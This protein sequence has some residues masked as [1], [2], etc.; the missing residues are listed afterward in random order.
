[1]IAAQMEGRICAGI[2][3]NPAYVDVI[4]NR[5]A[6]FVGDYGKVRYRQMAGK[7]HMKKCR[8]CE[9]TKPLDEF[10]LDKRRQIYAARCKQCHDLAPRI[11][12]VCGDGFIGKTGQKACTTICKSRLRPKTYRNCDHCDQRFG[13]LHHLRSRFCS[14]KCHHASREKGARKASA[15][16]TKQARAANKAIEYAIKV[17]RVHR[18]LTCDAC[19]RDGRI[20]AAHYDYKRRLD[21]RWLCVSC[22][23]KWDKADPKGGVVKYA[24]SAP[25]RW[26]NFT[27]EAATLDGGGTFEATKEDRPAGTRVEAVAV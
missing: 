9:E 6:Q 10:H 2:E 23:R 4:V 8:R 21:V 13:P 20:E 27:G 7:Y 18:P 19:S 25:K 11:C 26:Q 14:Q 15:R 12:V 3:I 24:A 16:P 5:F 1:M 22:H 17:G